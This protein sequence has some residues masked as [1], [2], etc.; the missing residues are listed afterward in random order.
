MLKKISSFYSSVLIFIVYTVF[1]HLC[2]DFLSDK[3]VMSFIAEGAF[4]DGL[5]FVGFGVLL[6]CLIF[7]RDDFADKKMS[8][9]AFIFLTIAAILREMGIQ[10]ALTTHDTTAIKLRFFTNPNNPLYEKIISAVLVL[11]VLITIL[12]LLIKYTPFLIKGIFK[13][14]PV[15]WT[16]SVFAF[17]A[18]I[19]KVFDRLPSI[20]RFAGMEVCSTEQA[21]YSILE[22]GIESLLPMLIVLA[23]YQYH[24]LKTQ[25][26]NKGKGK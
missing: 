16:M 8:W 3:Q 4:T 11:S 15:A 17:G 6:A 20:L 25:K 24:Q 2:F 21:Y 23:L 5:T 1:L 14:N 26:I 13:L 12:Y 7:Y 19:S 10:H 18:I 22:E 9:R